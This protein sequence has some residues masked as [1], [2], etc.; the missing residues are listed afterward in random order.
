MFDR[1]K[2]PCELIIN[3]LGR[4]EEKSETGGIVREPVRYDDRRYFQRPERRR[5]ELS[6]SLERK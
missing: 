4:E 2:L 5:V 3:D 6:R 1:N